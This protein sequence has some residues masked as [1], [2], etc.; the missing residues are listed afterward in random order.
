VNDADKVKVKATLGK[1]VNLEAELTNLMGRGGR[2]ANYLAK[3]GKDNQGMDAAQKA[4]MKSIAAGI[5]KASKDAKPVHKELLACEMAGRDVKV[6][7]KYATAKE[8][9][10]KFVGKRLVTARKLDQDAS[11]LT[12]TITTLL[13]F[14]YPGSDNADVRV[15]VDSLTEFSRLFAELRVLL[16]KW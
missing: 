7:A 10:D 12:F 6:L 9:R 11:K 3:Y 8:F 5:S 13:S 1:C 15:S 2:A 4:K 14:G 16:A